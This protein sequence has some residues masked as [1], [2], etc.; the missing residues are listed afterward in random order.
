ML[1]FLRKKS[2]FNHIYIVT[3]YFI[4]RNENTVEL[5]LSVLFTLFQIKNLFYIFTE[6][7]MP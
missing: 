6:N 1:K 2:I 3:I 5:Q 7:V 4:L